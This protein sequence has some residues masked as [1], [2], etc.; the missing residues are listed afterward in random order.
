MNRNR[1]ATDPHALSSVIRAPQLSGLAIGM[2]SAIAA[3][4]TGASVLGLTA[5][6]PYHHE[7]ENWVLQAQGQDI[8]NLLAVV[9][10]L[11]SAVRSRAGSFRAAQWWTGALLY[12]LY[13]Y[14]IYAFAVHFSRLFIVYVAILGLVT[15]SL[16]AAL[17]RR[18]GEPAHPSGRARVVAGVV[19]IGVGA[20]FSLVWL[21][22][23]VPATLTGQI[24]PSVAAAGLR[25]NPVHAIDL[26]VVL[27][28]MIV[29]GVLAVRGNDAG[30]RWTVPALVFSVLMGSSI[31]AAML[32]AWA[33]GVGALVPIALIGVVVLACLTAATAYQRSTRGP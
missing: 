24:P 3:L 5:Q 4:V 11:M 12:L 28:G 7:T 33:G 15:F 17:P 6:W 2:S 29:L 25:V 27:P 10:L 22:E 32:L 23:L 19:L 14:I 21:S 18:A 13:A 30:T 8:G 26:S 20:L 9:V 31:I 1:R 16:I